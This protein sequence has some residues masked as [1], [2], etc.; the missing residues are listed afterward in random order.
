[1]AND[2][3]SGDSPLRRLV[4]FGVLPALLPPLLSF[5]CLRAK[6]PAQIRVVRAP[7]GR[8]CCAPPRHAAE[9]GSAAGQED[10][11]TAELASRRAVKSLVRS[12][13]PEIEPVRPAV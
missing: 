1:M 9:V 10:A 11:E 4:L 12:M 6:V 8:P 7:A 5:I 2:M 3:M 13:D